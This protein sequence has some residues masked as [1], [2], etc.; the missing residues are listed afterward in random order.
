M[1]SVVVF[2]KDLQL[3]EG[4]KPITVYPVVPC[5]ERLEKGGQKIRIMELVP[6][7]GRVVF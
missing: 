1:S 3:L 2:E 6:H 7:S 4:G 5:A